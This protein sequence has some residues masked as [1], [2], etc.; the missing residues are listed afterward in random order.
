[1]HE[2]FI[3]LKEEKRD[4]IINSALME[5]AAKGYD[6]ASTNEMVKAAGISK[7]AL[8]HYFVSK[9]DLFFFL[10]DYVFE[11]VSKE[12]YE[13]IGHCGGDLLTRY[14][15][16]AMLKGAVYQRYPPMFEFIKRLTVEKSP[17][18]AAELKEQLEKIM[19]YGYQCLLGNLDT[20]LFRQDVPVN[21]IRDLITWALEN[22]G[23][24]SLEL[25]GE[26]KLEDINIEALNADF[27]EYLD[28][29]RK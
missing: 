5:F 12:F 11:V 20:S 13:Q 15:R 1:M 22:Y 25:I 2:N 3:G 8:F 19:N 16:A 10:C 26:K 17:E 18:I 4:I 6:L 28:V 24:R 27:D 23:N 21:K 14:S 29:L 7:G 9:K